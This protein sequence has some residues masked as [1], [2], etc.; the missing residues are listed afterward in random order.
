VTLQS[1]L[2]SR[3]QHV[4]EMSRSDDATA[5]AL[6][7][8]HVFYLDELIRDF[9]DLGWESEVTVVGRVQ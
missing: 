1:L 7:A 8:C 9:Q 4:L 3:R 6:L 5:R 2:A